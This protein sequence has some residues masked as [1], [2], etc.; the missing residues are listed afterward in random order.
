MSSFGFRQPQFSEDLAYLPIWL[1]N[2]QLETSPSD[3]LIPRDSI[4]LENVREEGGCKDCYLFLSGEGNS[5]N[6]VDQSSGNL[7]HLSLHIS[8]DGD[9]TNTQSQLLYSSDF[10]GRSSKFP[11]QHQVED[12]CRW[13]KNSK[14]CQLEMGNDGGG[15]TC[16]VGKCESSIQIR[17]NKQ[18]RGIQDDGNSNVMETTDPMLHNSGTCG[19]GKADIDDAVEL[20]IA[21]SEALAI[22][23]L[24]KVESDCEG[25]EMGSILEAALRV[26][27]ARLE[28]LDDGC[29]RYDDI[30]EFDSLSDLDDSVMGDA[31][32]DVGLS[33]RS[34]CVAGSD[35]SRVK[36]TPTMDEHPKN[37]Q[38][39]NVNGLALS[40]NS[41]ACHA[42]RSL[43]QQED[44]SQKETQV[45]YLVLKEA[46]SNGGRKKR[47]RKSI[48]KYFIHEAS[49][50]SESADVAANQVS[51]THRKQ[52][53]ASIASQSSINFNGVGDKAHGGSFPSQEVRCS[54]AS[55]SDP[56]CSVVPC[57]I[58][59]E[60][61]VSPA[62]HNQ[63]STE[64]QAQNCISHK[65]ITGMHG[66]GEP[67]CQSL[68]IDDQA[69][70]T[71]AG[72][73]HYDSLVRR[74]L[75][76]LKNYSKICLDTDPICEGERTHCN[77]DLS[78]KM[79][80]QHFVGPSDKEREGLSSDKECTVDKDDEQVQ[81]S[82]L[83]RNVVGDMEDRK[84]SHSESGNDEPFLC[85]QSS[86]QG[87]PIVVNRTGHQLQ[88]CEL[89]GNNVS[90][91]R[92]LEQNPPENSTIK[93][94]PS[95]ILCTT[96][97]PGRKR[98]HFS[99]ETH[100]EQGKGLLLKSKASS[101]GVDPTVRDNKRSKLSKKPKSGSLGRQKCLLGR[102]QDFKNLIFHG[103]EFL[104]TGFSCAKE[105][106]LG[107]TIQKFG[108]IVLS[109]IPSHHRSPSCIGI[110]RS[111]T[112]QLPVIIC[113]RKLQTSKF[114][115][116]CAVNASILKAKWITDSI[117]GGT[118]APSER[119]L[120]LPNQADTRLPRMVSTNRKN[121][122]H[123]FDRVGIMLHGKPS[124][125]KKL[126]LI[127]KV[128]KTLQ[129]LLWGLDTG[130]VTRGVIVAEDQS[131]R[132]LRHL[133]HC[134]E[135]QKIALMSGTWI[136]KALHL[137]KLLVPL[138]QRVD[139]PG[140]PEA[141]PDSLAW[142]QEF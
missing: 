40:S 30:D 17:S 35:V 28:D 42:N 131:S 62:N 140:E 112:Q 85:V 116:G 66:S 69:A 19:E 103:L 100:H 89:T 88:A 10:A 137:G 70:S 54:Y 78:S 104:I 3:S 106:E 141:L 79:L 119:Y 68:S 123:I 13:D 113:S 72:D 121:R 61:D 77:G 41:M 25:L 44:I 38:E 95:R 109:D 60:D 11:S 101:S 111:V 12:L 114:L 98:V 132:V 6:S 75:G 107:E 43:D 16:P 64:V 142:S 139:T 34:S 133:Q 81:D 92:C 24:M 115:Y 93:F 20:S 130:K 96:T 26:K 51:Y 74:Q 58:P 105:R 102:A 71:V 48:A 5:E 53:P 134:A 117:A 138:Q 23:E 110:M 128:F 47:T 84:E 118:I 63:D 27:Q 76:T 99:V 31:F 87:S 15:V 29:Y 120:V 126:S 33:A 129:R 124:F 4:D 14:A 52:N 21:A 136:V 46:N 125:C 127:I 91:A 57:S 59:L 122:H 55:A 108:G 82:P 45:Q 49:F 22:H 135:E 50:L 97:N 73:E 56:L 18:N 94:N 83:N 9:S 80:N 67:S 2:P 32:L 36:A 90:S 1:Q 65:S 37:H 7:L 39:E 86:I 8:L